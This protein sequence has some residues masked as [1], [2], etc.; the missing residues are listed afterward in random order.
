[1]L[2]LAL[3]SVP[4]LLMEDRHVLLMWG[5]WAIVAVFALDLAVRLWLNEELSTRKY[6]L[7]YWYDVAIVVLTLLPFLRPLR[8]LRA[9]QVLR[10]VRGPIAAYKAMRMLYGSLHGKGLILSSTALSIAAVCWVYAVES[11][12][13]ND[14]ENKIETL[15]DALWWA[16][17][18]VTTVGYGD[19][20]P[21]TAT[22]K[23]A[24]F[25]LIVCGVSLFGLITANVSARF[26][27]DDAINEAPLT[28]DQMVELISGLECPNCG[29]TRAS[30]PTAAG[31]E[32][33][34]SQPSPEDDQG[35]Q[36]DA[37][38]HGALTATSSSS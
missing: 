19:L 16:A 13:D 32:Q 4:L 5:G 9:L 1:M 37:S 11:S 27:K 36:A 31:K 21:E 30:H 33:S 23:V 25:V 15:T 29:Y 8:A 2:V 12:A 28:Y 10:V 22:A 14:A 7:R 20:Y 3:A 17:A 26:L 18:T 6:L 38:T 35:E 34:S 24:A